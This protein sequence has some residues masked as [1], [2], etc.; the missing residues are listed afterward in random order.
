MPGFVSAVY[1]HSAGGG[2]FL[3]VMQCNKKKKAFDDGRA[4]YAA[5][6]WRWPRTRS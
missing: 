3:A 4:R 2:K 5:T 6:S 1:A